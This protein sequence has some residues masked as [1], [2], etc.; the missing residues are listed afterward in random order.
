MR[1]RMHKRAESQAGSWR[2][3]RL[4]CVSRAQP[5]FR[6]RTGLLRGWTKARTALRIGTCTAYFVLWAVADRGGLR[7]GSCCCQLRPEQSYR[8]PCPHCPAALARAQPRAPHSG[9]SRGSPGLFRRY[10][11]QICDAIRHMHAH[12]IMHRDIK[13]ANI[14]LS[15]EGAVKLGD[16]GLGRA[17]SSQTF[18]AMS[19]VVWDIALRLHS[20]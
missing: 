19:K 11:V 9:A 5:S 7:K 15:A 20:R 16:L 14:F 18:E 3:C 2:P 12:R 8:F 4:V 1:C 10:F 6:V 17:F 13:P